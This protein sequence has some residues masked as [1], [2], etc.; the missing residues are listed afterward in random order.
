MNLYKFIEKRFLRDKSLDYKLNYIFFLFFMIPIVGCLYFSIKYNLL[1]DRSIPLFFL[2]FLSVSLFGLNLLRK[3]FN[4]ISGFSRAISSRVDAAFPQEM[5]Q[6][7]G[8]ELGRLERS[9]GVLDAH[10]FGMQMEIRSR[11]Q[12]LGALK[13]LSELCYLTADADELLNVTLERAL[14]MTASDIGSVL[15][16]DMPNREHFT[17]HTSLGLEEYIT[18]G[19]RIPFESSVAKYAILNKAPMVV[20]DI[21][22][23]HRI[24]RSNRDHYGSTSFICMPIKTSRDII[25]VMTLSTRNKTRVYEPADA[26]ALVTMLSIAG[27]SY[28][29]LVLSQRQKTST[30][31]LTTLANVLHLINT[32][33]QASDIQHMFLTEIRQAVPFGEALIL[34]ED[35][36]RADHLALSEVMVKTPILLTKGN[37]IALEPGSYVERAFK[38]EN[39]LLIH[40]PWAFNHGADE[41]L[42]GWAET[43]TTIGLIPL[44]YQG[45][46]RGLLV[47]FAHQGF[48]FMAQRHLLQWL[49]TGL[50]LGIERSRLQE[51]IRKRKQELGSL[52]QIGSALASSTFDISQVLNYTMDMIRVIMNVS[53]GS[54]YLREDNELV[55]AAAFNDEPCTSRLERLKLGQGLP[56][57]VAARG[58]AIILNEGRGEAS[59]FMLDLETT[60]GLPPS[61]ALC[62]PMISQGKVIGVIEVVNKLSGD[63]TSSDQDLLQSIAASV[64]IAIEN[65]NLYKETVAMAE[66]ERGVRRMFQKFVPKEVLDQILPGANS[67]VD[68]VEEL[69]TLTL[70]NIDLRG[71]TKLSTQ[72]GPQK[73][74][75]LLNHF[76]SVMGGIVFKHGG[77]VD[78]YLG[79]GFLAIFG[80]PVAR[81]GDADNAVNAAL[82]MKNALTEIN[83]SIGAQMGVALKIGI[84]IHTGEVV[85]GNIGFE[86]KMDY[87]V[88]GDSVNKV[89]RLQDRT[90]PYPNSILI[91]EMTS[92]AARLPLDLLELEEPL[93]ETRIFELLGLADEETALA[94]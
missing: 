33:N 37:Q 57:Y 20:A 80:A 88:I 51:A 35:E 66:N 71:F 83:T 17:V 24:S 69:R 64:S 65:A 45:Q 6:M 3:V 11:E 23:D 56:G 75:R 90:K 60:T 68:T 25:G 12:E 2:G 41:T 49:G 50:A 55:F 74:V 10:V 58:E 82:E 52:K 28:E 84:S 22:S 19:E 44:H 26:E 5:V 54:L 86:M 78:K 76:F 15:L 47:L 21:E 81:P 53:S 73:T 18:P 36:Y 40:P 93:G 89:F 7:E 38:A 34:F 61:S 29:N 8:D 4:E 31:E 46:A 85:V 13:S 9:F 1:A 91:S 48:D 72:L 70:M 39:P 94:G 62:V 43:P 16:L 87:T 67:G 59:L 77:I 92:R 27:F 32:S 14:E 79:D 63:F 42:L 30:T